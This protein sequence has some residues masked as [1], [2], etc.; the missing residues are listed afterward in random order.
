M[1]LPIKPISDIGRSPSENCQIDYSFLSSIP[2]PNK[3]TV[4]ASNSDASLLF[5]LW[6]KAEK[7]G[8]DLFKVDSSKF[9]NNDILRLKSRG[10]L[11]GGTKEVKFTKK[12]K[13]V[14]TTMALAEPNKFQTTRQHKPYNE[15]LASMD[16]K[17]KKGYRI[18]KFAASTSNNLRLS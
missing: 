18:P 7:I 13:M 17:G 12:A 8:E 10:F 6:T 1:P 14:V 2:E 15:I 5:D 16:K 9:D 11:A 4:V 3:K